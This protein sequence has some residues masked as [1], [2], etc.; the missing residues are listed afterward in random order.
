ML[1]QSFTLSPTLFDILYS[2]FNLGSAES[3]HLEI[4]NLACVLNRKYHTGAAFPVSEPH[5]LTPRVAGNEAA[6]VHSSVPSIF[7]N[8]I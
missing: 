6:N 4:N 7:D 8:L 1:V 2:A 5:T 3:L